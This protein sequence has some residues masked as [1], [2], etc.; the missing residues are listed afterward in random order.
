MFIRALSS[1]M[2]I[3]TDCEFVLR[4]SC[5]TGVS[6]N[7]VTSGGQHV[8]R[9]VFRVRRK[10]CDTCAWWPRTSLDCDPVV[11]GYAFYHMLGPVRWSVVLAGFVFFLVYVLSLLAEVISKIWFSCESVVVFSKMVTTTELSLT[12]WP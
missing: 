10:M 9:G 6:F 8:G 3:V 12:A 7:E 1:T 4:A 11:A 2:R 5:L